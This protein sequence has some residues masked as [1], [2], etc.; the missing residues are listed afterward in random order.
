MSLNLDTRFVFGLLPRPLENCVKCNHVLKSNL[1]QHQYNTR[2][3]YVPNLPSVK[4]TMYRKS[5]LFTSVKAIS[6]VPSE[7]RGAKPFKLFVRKCKRYLLETTHSITYWSNTISF[8]YG[9][10]YL[11]TFGNNDK[12]IGVTRE[13]L[14]VME[15]FWE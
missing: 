6:G 7:L 4:S 5:I 10:H 11:K 3:K 8:H 9:P 13:L 2:Q 1:K 14:G 12:L 15:N